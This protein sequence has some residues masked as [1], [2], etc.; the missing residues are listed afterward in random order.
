MVGHTYE[1]ICSMQY[2]SHRLARESAAGIGMRITNNWYIN[3]FIFL[4]K[5]SRNLLRQFSPKNTIL[6]RYQGET[7]TLISF[8]ILDTFC[9]EHF[10]TKQ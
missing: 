8:D 2:F 10:W 6:M 4:K 3:P 7:I 1:E 9:M 5:K